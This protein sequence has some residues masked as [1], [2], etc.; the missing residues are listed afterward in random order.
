MRP[1]ILVVRRTHV[2]LGY[3]VE[4]A[5]SRMVA[6]ACAPAYRILRDARSTV[7]R[8]G[9]STAWCVSGVVICAGE[10]RQGRSE[11]VRDKTHRPVSREGDR[12]LLVGELDHGRAESIYSPFQATT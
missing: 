3:G 10:S 4:A 6:W 5:D 7:W 11:I 8:C 9:R 2:A 12:L 1:R